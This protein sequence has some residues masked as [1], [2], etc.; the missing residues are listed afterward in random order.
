M[1]ICHM[2]GFREKMALMN[3]YSLLNILIS[4]LVSLLLSVSPP[5]YWSNLN[6]QLLPKRVRAP[7][8]FKLTRSEIEVCLCPLLFL[9]YYIY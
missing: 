7:Q 1:V 8:S 4:P 6:G 5:C 9:F 3:M 2:S